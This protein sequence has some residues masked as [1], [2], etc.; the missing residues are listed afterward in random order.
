MSWYQVDRPGDD[1][2][3]TTDWSLFPQAYGILMNARLMFPEDLSLWKMKI[4]TRR[5]LFVDDHVLAHVENLKREFHS[6]RD[7]PANPILREGWPP[8]HL[9]GPGTRLPDVLQL[10]GIVPAGRLF[11]R[12]IELGVPH[13]RPLRR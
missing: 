9:P 4:D 8:I 1:P 6:P 12:R 11:C 5:Q 2:E 10:T 13:P 7:H 3:P